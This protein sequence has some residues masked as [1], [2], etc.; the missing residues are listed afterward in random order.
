MH[1]KTLPFS[2]DF[3]KM[4]TKTYPTPFVIYDQ[5]AILENAKELYEAFSRVEGFKDY[6]AVKATPNPTLIKLLKES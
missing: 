2:L 6:F 5:K 3:I 1:T 4:L